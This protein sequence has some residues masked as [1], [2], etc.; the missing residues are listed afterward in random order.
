LSSQTDIFEMCFHLITLHPVMGF[1]L[2]P[3]TGWRVKNFA[4]G[5][6]LI[7]QMIFHDF[8]PTSKRH[9]TDINISNTPLSYQDPNIVIRDL[10]TP[11]SNRQNQNHRTTAAFTVNLNF[12]PASLK[13]QVSL[14]MVRSSRVV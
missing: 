4:E 9:Q 11:T 6:L 14:S 5:K 10:P 2:R 3:I 8:Q 7:R 1:F 12:K 13:N